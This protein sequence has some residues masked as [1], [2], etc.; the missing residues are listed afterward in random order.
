MF[1]MVTAK[2][3]MVAQRAAVLASPTLH[4]T[5]QGHPN[6]PAVRR[7][8][9]NAWGTELLLSLT[10]EYAIEDELI[11][12][13]N[14]WGA[15]QAYYVAYHAF[16]AYLVAN[17]ETRPETHPKTQR[18]FADRWTRRALQMPPWT[19]AVGER[20]FLN[21][22]PG[23][24]VD[25]G[26][27][28][29]KFCD[30]TNCWDI[31]GHALKSTREGMIPDAMSTKRE[32]KRK[33][34][35]RDWEEEEAVRLAAGRKLRKVPTVRLP[36]LTVAD[37]A[38]VRSRVR[39]Y[40]TM[41]Y[42]YRL[43]IKSNYEDSTMFTDG[44]TDENA[45]K[46]VH[47]DLVRLASSVLRLHELHIRKLIGLGPMKKMMDDWIAGSMPANRQLGVAVRR[48]VVLAP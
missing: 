27:H 14:N 6:L 24:A 2:K 35:R 26:V 23:R 43:R 38:L 41:D 19:Y 33:D 13:A 21:G 4:D 39:P 48:V 12:L 30:A 31:A 36:Q 16:Q 37:K 42:L 47:G 45:S 17:G 20:G 8:L 40:S 46:V 25:L 22:P 29:W 28:Q 44:P 3:A 11:R 1:P 18:M 34:A 9:S 10:R 5:P 7:S 32:N 15:V